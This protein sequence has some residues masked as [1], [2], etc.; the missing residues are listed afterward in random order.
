[1]ALI[2]KMKNLKAKDNAAAMKIEEIDDVIGDL[3]KE[4]SD[5]EFEEIFNREREEAASK[6][7]GQKEKAKRLRVHFKRPPKTS[8]EAMEALQEADKRF[9]LAKNFL[10]GR[11]GKLK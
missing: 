1:M 6:L 3:E 11:Q 2:K 7:D 4:K 9:E 5:R 10:T 8:E